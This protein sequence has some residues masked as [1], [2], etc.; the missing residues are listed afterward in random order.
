MKNIKP[1]LTLFLFLVVLISGCST[2]PV[3]CTEEAKICPDGSAVGRTEPNCEF[4]E[5]PKMIEKE[6]FECEESYFEFR[7]G[8]CCLD[9]DDSGIC[10]REELDDEAQNLVRIE[11]IECDNLP[12]DL[13]S[14][15]LTKDWI[16]DS[17]GCISCEA[18]GCS[19]T[20][21]D[22]LVSGELTISNTY[23]S[24]GGHKYTLKTSTKEYS[25]DEINVR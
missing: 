1:I 24:C 21:E 17:D 16:Q 23:V 5:C 9:V 7:E 10:D 4:A 19:C 3:A 2:K 22:Y 6:S 11:N 18:C 14:E 25:C 12:L 20:V 15:L 8:E 13:E